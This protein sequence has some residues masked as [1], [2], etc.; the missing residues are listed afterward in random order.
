MRRH[1]STVNVS[2]NA[3]PIGKSITDS[4]TATSAIASTSPPSSTS[5]LRRRRLSAPATASTT[6]TIARC[7]PRSIRS[8]GDPLVGRRCRSWSSRS[9]SGSMATATAAL[10]GAG[11]GG[12][13]PPPG[14]G[15]TVRFGAKDGRKPEPTSDGAGARRDRGSGRPPGAVVGPEPASRSAARRS[16]GP[17]GAGAEAPVKKASCDRVSDRRGTAS[18]VTVTR[19]SRRAGRLPR[20]TRSAAPVVAPRRR[21]RARKASSLAVTRTQEPRVQR[22]AGAPSLG[23]RVAARIGRVNSA[24]ARPNEMP[25]PCPR[26]GR[27]AASRRARRGVAR[28]PT[29]K[30]DLPSVEGVPD[31]RLGLPVAPGAAATAT[32]VAVARR[33]RPRKRRH[34]PPPNRGCAAP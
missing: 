9:A 27:A 21:P 4:R 10:A 33:S 20:T 25:P 17:P 32:R 34:P 23:R 6:S 1:C 30:H 7:S 26:A 11:A 13:Y 28:A 22:L 5:Q 3:V 29:R 18:R 8:R 2:Q 24:A 19:I 16:P 31:G 15:T 12:R 14:D